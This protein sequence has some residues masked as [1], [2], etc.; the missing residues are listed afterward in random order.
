LSASRF[1]SKTA[2]GLIT[3][4]MLTGKKEYPL[5]RRHSSYSPSGRSQST[6]RFDRPWRVLRSLASVWSRC[7]N[8]KSQAFLSAGRLRKSVRNAN[9]RRDISPKGVS[10]PGCR[11]GGHGDVLSVANLFRPESFLEKLTGSG[12]YRMFVDEV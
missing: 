5:S 2:C 9:A 6:C 3:S 11:P 1:L 10:S 8:G 12:P 7:Q 4:L